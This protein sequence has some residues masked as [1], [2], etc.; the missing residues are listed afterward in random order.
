[1]YVRGRRLDD[2]F[3][4]ENPTKVANPPVCHRETLSTISIRMLST[5]NKEEEPSLIS[6]AASY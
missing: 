1:M 4:G 3:I 2:L 6:Q 5:N